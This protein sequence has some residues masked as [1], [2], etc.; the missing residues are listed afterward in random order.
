MQ[1]LPELREKYTYNIRPFTS[2]ANSSRRSGVG[3]MLPSDEDDLDEEDLEAISCF[4]G[5]IP[6]ANGA[7]RGKG[8]VSFNLIEGISTNSHLFLFQSDLLCVRELYITAVI[9]LLYGWK[10]FFHLFIKTVDPQDTN[11]IFLSLYKFCFTYQ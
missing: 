4:T 9:R 3:N 6:S 8:I 5:I 11:F 1:Q 10:I 2:A 7:S